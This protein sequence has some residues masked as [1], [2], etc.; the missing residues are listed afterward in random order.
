MDEILETNR[1]VTAPGSLMISIPPLLEITSPIVRQALVLRIL[2][3]VSYEPWGSL[4]SEVGRRQ[5]SVDRLVKVLWDAK[6]LRYRK[7]ISFTVGSGVW[8]K[9]A[10]VTKGHILKTVVKELNIQDLM[11]FAH[12][13]PSINHPTAPV[14]DKDNLR[15]VM[16]DRLREGRIAW[17]SNEGPD[18]L[19]VLFDRRFLIRFRLDKMP[20][21]LF[22]ALK[23]NGGV[24]IKKRSPWHLPEVCF[25]QSK[26]YTVIHTLVQREKFT[27]VREW[28]TKTYI[29]TESNWITIHYV[30]PISSL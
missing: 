20:E 28:G 19:E 24:I 23:T 25:K 4:R 16:T 2:R 6:A 8:W 7:N 10:F 5:K 17:E 18:T 21:D 9:P 1:R 27:W 26:E 29:D 12:R 3:Y 30:R 14:S 22:E 11:W 13:H 15:I